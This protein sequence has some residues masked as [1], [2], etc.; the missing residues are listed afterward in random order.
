MYNSEAA[1]SKPSTCR[2]NAA[3]LFT[4][5]D[6]EAESASGEIL[7]TELVLLGLALDVI[8]DRSVWVDEWVLLDIAATEVLVLGIT[9]WVRYQ[10]CHSG[11]LVRAALR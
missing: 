6:A 9:V 1:R 4:D 2:T 3:L 5:V 11:G 7:N 10:L 8:V